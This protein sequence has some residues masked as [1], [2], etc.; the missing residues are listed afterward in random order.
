MK[1]KDFSPNWIF[2]FIF[3][4]YFPDFTVASLNL[5]GTFVWK[6]YVFGYVIYRYLYFSPGGYLCAILLEGIVLGTL[7][8]SYFEFRLMVLEEM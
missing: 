3:K 7:Q 8:W 5:R 4:T 6:Y 1:F 2:L